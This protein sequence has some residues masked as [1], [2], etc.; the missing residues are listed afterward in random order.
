MDYQDRGPSFKVRVNWE[1]YTETSRKDGK[2]D[3]Y[4]GRAGLYNL[5]MNP[6]PTDPYC[7]GSL[8]DF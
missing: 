4:L 7:S 8:P 2:M 6:P 1:Q 3:M 5:S